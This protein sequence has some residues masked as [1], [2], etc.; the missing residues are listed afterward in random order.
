[1]QNRSLL[2]RRLVSRMAILMIGLV[3]IA[4]LALPAEAKITCPI[5]L[6]NVRAESGAGAAY[7]QALVAGLK[8]GFDEINA[9]GGIA[10]CPVQLIA[11]DS[12]SLP[13]NAA[14][15][16]QRLLYQDQ[17]SLVIGS[18]LSLEVLAMMELTE[19]AEIPLYVPSAASAK[20]TS[21]GGKWVW[22]QSIV[23]LDGAKV[24]ASYLAGQKWDKVGILFENTDYGKIPVNT[25]LIPSLKALGVDVIAT[26][27]F[28]TGDSDISSPLLRI[29]DAGAKHLIFWGRDKEGALAMRQM[30]Q[31]GMAM[32]V[33]GN[34][35]LVYPN[36]LSLLSDDVQSKLDFIAIAQFS[37]TAKEPKLKAWIDRYMKQFGRLPDATSIDG[38]DAPFVLKKAIEAAGDL[39]PASLQKAL[40]EVSYEGTG[41]S[42]AFDKTGQALRPFVIVKMTAKSGEGFEVIRTIEPK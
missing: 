24:L 38:Y 41:G 7:G 37:W 8:M 28:N 5:R 1:M 16:T 23:D 17:V 10:G 3:S 18:S 36:F 13:A 20:I 25:V 39:A 15:L 33:A 30:L 11:Y 34:T 26:E 2:V 14:T 12:Q 27:T 42:I 19:G 32:P 4:E 9:A 21:Q 35:G 31:L 22:R 6:G 29:R 40:S